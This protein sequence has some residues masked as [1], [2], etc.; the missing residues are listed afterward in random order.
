MLPGQVRGVVLLR[1]AGFTATE[2][3]SLSADVVRGRIRG[4]VCRGTET[5]LRDRA[6]KQIR[7][8]RSSP[9]NNLG[10]TITREAQRDSKRPR[11]LHE[12]YCEIEDGALRHDEGLNNE[13]LALE[14]FLAAA[15]G[16]M[17]MADRTW[18]AARQLLDDIQRAQRLLS[19]RAAAIPQGKRLAK[20]GR[21]SAKGTR[22]PM[23]PSPQRLP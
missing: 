13:V 3:V 10:Q 6:A 8:R 16:D 7:D 22:G 15:E 17:T 9:P 11:K 14:E 2:W 1:N 23:I 4:R 5:W 20:G 18:A 21:W 12:A 19:C